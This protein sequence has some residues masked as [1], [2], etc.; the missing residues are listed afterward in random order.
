MNRA[1]VLILCLFLVLLAERTTAAAGGEMSEEMLSDG[2]LSS[3]VAASVVR[4]Y[5]QVLSPVDGDRCRMQ[6]TCSEY[7]IHAIRKHGALMGVIL[8]ADR[9]MREGEEIQRS[10]PAHTSKG[11]RYLDP[12]GANDFWMGSK[13]EE[14]PGHGE[15]LIPTSLKK[16]QP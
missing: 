6:P 4:F 2:S 14:I 16:K 15:G 13:H 9:M 10:L 5:Q 8:A 1:M 11:L 3:R 12:L 7:A